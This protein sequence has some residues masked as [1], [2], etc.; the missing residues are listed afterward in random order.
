MPGSRN[1]VSPEDD[2]L[3]GVRGR[4]GSALMVSS[5]AGGWS[6][7]RKVIELAYFSGLSQREI[8]ALLGEPLG[9][10]KARIR[11]GVTKLHGTVSRRL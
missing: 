11:R 1:N 6:H 3:K 10:I 7:C 9:T 4:V 8:A 2:Y 5:P